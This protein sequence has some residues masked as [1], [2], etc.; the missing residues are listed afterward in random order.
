MRSLIFVLMML[1]AP[2]SLADAR[3]VDTLDVLEIQQGDPWPQVYY[4]NSGDQSSLRGRGQ[5][6]QLDGVRVKVWIEVG[7]GPHGAE[8]ITVVPEDDQ[9]IAVPPVADVQDGDSVTIVIMPPMF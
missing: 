1:T 5:V 3:S 7:G 2:M 9:V 4:E 8:R 6:L